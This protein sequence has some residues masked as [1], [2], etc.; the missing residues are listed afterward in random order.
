MINGQANEVNEK[1]HIAD[2]LKA[3]YD[4]GISN[5]KD[6]FADGQATKHFK[7]GCDSAVQW[8]KES[9][10]IEKTAEVCAE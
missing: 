5:V 8:L 2:E 6:F 4:K 9:R 3:S 10:V 1:Y 7:E